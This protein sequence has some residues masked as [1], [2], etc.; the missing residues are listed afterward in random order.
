MFAILI[1]GIL[2]FALSQLLHIIVWRIKPPTGYGTWLPSLVV[3]FI[4]LGA[5]GALGL[6]MFVDIPG[7]SAAL[8]LWIEW[9]AVF[10]LHGSLAVVYIIG[11]T[12]IS[13]FSPS[14]E[15]IKTLGR[16][17]QGVS[18]KKLVTPFFEN[19]ALSDDRLNNLVAGNLI[20]KENEYLYLAPR[21]RQMT[22][23]VLLYRH[24]L[25]LPDG[26]GG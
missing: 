22:R 24:I 9:A 16:S 23:W 10:L 21:G 3:I 2:L 19:T 20:R 14:M 15:L 17:A 7:G 5:L 12:A 26:E 4:L 18:R 8:P 13:A 11:Y 1:K 6:V 25:G